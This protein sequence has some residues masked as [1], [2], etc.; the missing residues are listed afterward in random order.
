MNKPEPPRGQKIAL[1]T[2]AFDGSEQSG[3]TY[4]ER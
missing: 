4:A 1:P 2:P 3:R